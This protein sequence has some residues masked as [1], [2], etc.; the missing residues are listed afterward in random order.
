MPELAAKLVRLRP[1]LIVAA[2]SQ[3]ARTAKDR[4]DKD[5]GL[6]ATRSEGE[7]LRDY[8]QQERESPPPVVEQ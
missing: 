4:T 8:G 5:T 6:S 7:K 2:A 1:D 3:P